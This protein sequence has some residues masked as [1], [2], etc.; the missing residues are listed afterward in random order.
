MDGDDKIVNKPATAVNAM[1][2][3][4]KET[5]EILTPFAFKIDQSLFGIALAAP[6]RRGLALLIDLLLVAIL[7]GAPGE[8]LAILIAITLFNISSKKRAAK[9][10]KKSG[11]KNKMLA[12]VGAIIIFLVLIDTLP[13]L[14][15]KLDSFNR[16]VE[17]AG[18]QQTPRANVQQSAAQNKEQK[19]IRG[20]LSLASMFAISQSECLSYQCWQR[21]SAELLTI[22]VKQ[23]PSNEEAQQYIMLLLE[24]IAENSHIAPAQ[25]ETLSQ[26]LK[27]L[28]LQ[29]LAPTKAS[30][31]SSVSQQTEPA[32]TPLNAEEQGVTTTEQSTNN[33][34][35]KGFAWLKGLVEE[36]GIGFGWA[37]FYFTMFTSV[38]FGQTPGKKL[39]RIRVLQLDGTRLSLWDSFGRY[40]GY[41]AGV[42]T[43]LLGFAQIYWDPNRQAI[44]D[45]ISATIV[46]DD[47]KAN[48]VEH[49]T[50]DR[51][52]LN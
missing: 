19:V 7:S 45:K 50:D 37:A 18:Q 43:G 52:T 29:M 22:Y 3:S 25:Q 44:H 27:Q 2:L 10:D 42:A 31:A 28:N 51:N 20:T 39:C 36:L 34:V 35:Y 48:S 4:A 38:W 30:A 49:L 47:S 24:Q 16:Q 26:H 21:L 5:R 14:F 41:G 6:W 23:G 40:G 46:V 13:L 8:L 32:L 33:T 1:P 15:A 12:S 11:L 9:L 17:Y